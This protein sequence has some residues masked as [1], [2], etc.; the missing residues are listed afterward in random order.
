M[1]KKS[2]HQPK[3]LKPAAW[4]NDQRFNRIELREPWWPPSAWDSL[5][6]ASE[7][8]KILFRFPHLYFYKYI[9]MKQQLAFEDL[10][11][12]MPVIVPG[13][14]PLAAEAQEPVLVINK[15]RKHN[16]MLELC[17]FNRRFCTNISFEDFVRSDFRILTPEEADA[18]VKK[19]QL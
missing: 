10:Y 8:A 18:Y 13:V 14:V 19:H 17:F 9:P 2:K 12:D 1:R 3:Q 15:I 5:F 16:Q 4:L 6:T 11:E 7:F